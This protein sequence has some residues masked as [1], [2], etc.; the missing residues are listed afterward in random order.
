MKDMFLNKLADL[1]KENE[2]AAMIRK[3]EENNLPTDMLAILLDDFSNDVIEATGE[4]FFAPVPDEAE[5]ELLNIVITLSEEVKAECLAELYRTIAA[6]NF[7]LESG[8]FAVSK[9]GST[10]CYKKVLTLPKEGM[11]LERDFDTVETALASA[12]TI[13]DMFSGMVMAVA[14]GR[15]S[16]EEVYEMI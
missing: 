6:V 15:M 8:A 3:K 14:D 7:Y 9:D 2:I 13:G 4:V 12:I 1:L 10:L 16:S 11:S 5:Y